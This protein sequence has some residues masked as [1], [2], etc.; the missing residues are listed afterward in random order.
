[1]LAGLGGEDGAGVMVLLPGPRAHLPVRFFVFGDVGGGD[2]GDGGAHPANQGAV[3]GAGWVGRLH[4]CH[5]HLE[6][7]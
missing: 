6:P 4:V 5:K 3:A 7:E 1:M 2:G